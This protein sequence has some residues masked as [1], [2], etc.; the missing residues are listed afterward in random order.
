MYSPKALGMC[1]GLLIGQTVKL[2]YS[3]FQDYGFRPTRRCGC[4]AKIREHLWLFVHN[5]V[6]NGLFAVCKPIFFRQDVWKRKVFLCRPPCSWR[7]YLSLPNKKPILN[8][9]GF[10]VAVYLGIIHWDCNIVL[11]YTLWWQ[12]RLFVLQSMVFTCACLRATLLQYGLCIDVMWLEWFLAELWAISSCCSEVEIHY[13]EK[14]QCPRGYKIGWFNKNWFLFKGTSVPSP[15]ICKYRLRHACSEIMIYCILPTYTAGSDT[16][17]FLPDLTHGME[18]VTIEPSANQTLSAFSHF[19]EKMACCEVGSPTSLF[20]T[21]S[22]SPIPSLPSSRV[23]ACLWRDAFW[24]QVNL[25]IS[26]L[27]Q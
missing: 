17:Y 16:T 2:G 9:V 1:L 13:V 12:V 10:L 7:L 11:S 27:S 21:K 5:Y 22:Q 24:T 8:V 3:R 6:S 26:S 14:A 4:A 25:L 15:G 18:S 23:S 20:K 19:N